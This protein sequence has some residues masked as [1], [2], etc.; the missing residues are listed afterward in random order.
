MFPNWWRPDFAERG[1]LRA[2][3]GIHAASPQNYREIWK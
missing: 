1:N 2:E 3:R